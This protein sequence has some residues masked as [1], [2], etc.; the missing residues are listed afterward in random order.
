MADPISPPMLRPH[1]RDFVQGFL[2]ADAPRHQLLLAPLGAGKTTAAMAIIASVLQ[3]TPARVLIVTRSSLVAEQFAQTRP[4]QSVMVQITKAWL[5]ERTTESGG[6]P[7]GWPASMVGVVSPDTLADR[8]V[9]KELLTSQWDLVVV[10]DADTDTLGPRAEKALQQLIGE[11]AARRLLAL[12]LG[13]QPADDRPLG[14]LHELHVTNW[15]LPFLDHPSTATFTH[16][17][18]PAFFERSPE[19]RR[20]L[21]QVRR[22]LNRLGP[23]A[24]QWEL[25]GLEEAASSSPYALQASALRALER[26]RSRRNALAHGSTSEDA[27]PRPSR[28]H[29]LHELNLTLQELQALADAVDQ[30]SVD[31][32]YTAFIDLVGTASPRFSHASTVVFCAQPSTADYLADCLVQ[33]ERPTTRV[34]AHRPA[35][36]D[37]RSAVRTP[38]A[39]IIVED[40]AV[41][42][43]DLQG[44][45]QAINYDLVPNVERMRARW[46]RLG[47]TDPH[48]R[49]PDIWTMIDAATEEGPEQR[50]LALMPFLAGAKH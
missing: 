31:A 43:L 35:L 2:A 30:L 14:S 29:E 45:G 18:H 22:L 8:W 40:E 23:T 41:N 1:Q 46:S 24:R 10:D 48:R 39:V 9:M 34:R 3:T 36:G 17:F 20:L 27:T 37:L 33:L 11:G 38:G 13:G 47:W 19:E 25:D 44:V 21:H 15:E 42:G 5:R 6:T 50:A 26:L 16:R 7:D 4:P 49:P 28:A 12:G 32:R